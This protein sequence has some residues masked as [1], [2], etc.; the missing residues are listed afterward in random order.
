LA[1]L[2]LRGAG[3]RRHKAEAGSELLGPL[4]RSFAL[5]ETGRM[6]PEIIFKSR[7]ALDSLPTAGTS[8]PLKYIAELHQAS[9]KT[10]GMRGGTLKL[11]KDA[12]VPTEGHLILVYIHHQ[13]IFF[14]VSK[15]VYGCQALYVFAA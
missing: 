1:S 10:P 3:V 2:L 11:I 14:V 6:V 4:Q 7:I 9:S 12:R 13:L 8:F 15:S 5:F